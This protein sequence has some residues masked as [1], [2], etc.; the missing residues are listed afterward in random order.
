MK[1]VLLGL[2][3][4]ALL[5][6]LDGLSALFV[7]EAEGMLAVIIVSATVKGI[8]NGLLVGLIARKTEGLG[9]NVLAGGGVGLVLS[10]L[11]AMPSGSYV[12]IIV[13]GLFIGLMLGFIVAKWGK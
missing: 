1:K 6:L 8:I 5:G 2:L 13:P 4:G 10:V 7:P 3:S 12:E 11:A 9:K